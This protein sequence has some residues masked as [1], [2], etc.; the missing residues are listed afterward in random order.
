[1]FEPGE[2]VVCVDANFDDRFKKLFTAL[3]TQNKVYVVRDIVA[4]NMPDLSR[5][6]ATYIVGLN[7]PQNQHGIEY[8]FNPSR[9]V[10]LD[11][12]KKKLE[13]KK[14]NKNTIKL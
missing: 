11:K 13:L 9:F 5:T 8:G 2:K 7:N 6:V 1:M 3:P 12:F 14:T 10:P 4:G